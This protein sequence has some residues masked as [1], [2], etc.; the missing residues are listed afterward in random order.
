MEEN[1]REENGK[2]YIDTIETKTYEEKVIHG[3]FGFNK[4]IRVEVKADKA[5]EELPK[6]K[7]PLTKKQKAGIGLGLILAAALGGRA[8]ANRKH[9]EEECD[10]DYDDDEDLDEEDEDDT[11]DSE[12]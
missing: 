4:T 2:V 11:D 12:E 7:K 5:G 8:L 9:D 3:P 6:E 1:R 10:E